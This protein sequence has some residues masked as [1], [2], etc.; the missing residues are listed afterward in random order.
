V[1]AESAEVLG[2][3]DQKSWKSL[4][5]KKPQQPEKIEP[6]V[7]MAIDLT[8]PVVSYKFYKVIMRP[9]SKLPKWHPGK[10]DKGWAFVDEIFIN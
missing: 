9:V 1:P 3:N 7:L 6:G 4:A 5:V 8:F 10:G 2:S